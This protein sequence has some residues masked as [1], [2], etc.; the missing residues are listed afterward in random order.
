MLFE[1]QWASFLRGG[2]TTQALRGASTRE[3]SAEEQPPK[4]KT[5]SLEM[6]LIN[7]FRNYTTSSASLLFLSEFPIRLDLYSEV[8]IPAHVV[9]ISKKDF[10]HERNFP[11][12]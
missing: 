1:G 7:L 10:L 3:R 4:L 9:S 11:S 2:V 6:M 12:L 5:Y 8:E